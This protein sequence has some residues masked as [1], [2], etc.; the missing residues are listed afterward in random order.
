MVASSRNFIGF[1]SLSAVVIAPNILNVDLMDVEFFKPREITHRKNVMGNYFL[2][3]K[4][5]D[6]KYCNRE[7]MISPSSLSQD[8]VG[9]FDSMKS[10]T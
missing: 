4:G 2:N 10:R 5:P 8:L 1:P 3:A 7:I 9:C 6:L